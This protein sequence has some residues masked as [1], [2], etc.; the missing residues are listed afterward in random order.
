MKLT[1][2]QSDKGDCLLLKSTDST[3]ILVDG[4]MRN[5]YTAHVAAVLGKLATDGAALDLVYVSHIDEDHISGVL[6]LVDDIVQ[7]RVF[8]FQ[9][10]QGNTTIEEPTSPRPPEVKAI[11]HNAFHEQVGDNAGPIEELLAASASI[12]SAS[13]SRPLLELAE[14]HRELALS[15]AQA[16]QLSRRIGADQLNIPL[17]AEF[18]GKLMFVR[19]D[20]VSIGLGAL[21]IRVIGPFKENL[22]KLRKEWNTWLTANQKRVRELQR[23]ARDDEDNLGNDVDRLIRTMEL[24]ARVFGDRQKVTAP[25]LASLMLYVEESRDGQ[26]PA[27]FLLTGDGHP[28][29]IILGLREHGQFDQQPEGIHVDVLKVQHHGSEHNMTSDFCRK[30]TADHYIFCGNGKHE[31]PDLGVVEMIIDSRV[32]TQVALSPNQQTA[33]KFTLWFNCSS[34]VPGND[35]SVEHM[36]KIERLVKQRA[37]NRPTLRFE[38]LKQSS[39]SLTV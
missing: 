23:Q 12:L 25:N 4:G 9:K 15:Q 38:F 32:G 26:P 3:H 6:Q 11:W 29:E 10:A 19:S 28:D 5:T 24:Q 33:N 34:D 20:N 21:T 17:N 2:F 31:N 16:I 8:D 37:Q 30:V 39:F 27:R 14:E 1:I 35:Q 22:A 36:R 13:K 7:W 18:G